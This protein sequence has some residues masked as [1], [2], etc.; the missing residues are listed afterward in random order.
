[1]LWR[2]YPPTYLPA[3]TYLCT[4]SF[5]II[6]IIII[7]ICNITH[8]PSRNILLPCQGSTP[9]SDSSSSIT[10][11]QLSSQFQAASSALYVTSSPT[12]CDITVTFT[13][14]SSSRSV[15]KASHFAV[16]SLFLGKFCLVASE[17]SISRHVPSLCQRLMALCLVMW[18][19]YTGWNI[20][21]G[22]CGVLTQDPP[23]EKSK[24]MELCVQV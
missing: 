10:V 9:Q 19:S 12:A 22:L 3:L 21:Y 2:T 23:S 5:K 13:T 18:S 20:L 15:T 16:I 7:T 14:H 11:L 24:D 17:T 4:Y 6:I 8:V 1:V